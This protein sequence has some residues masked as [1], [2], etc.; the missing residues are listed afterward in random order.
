MAL[1][2]AGASWAYYLDYTGALRTDLLPGYTSGVPLLGGGHW[3][4]HVASVAAWQKTQDVPYHCDL[5]YNSL[6]EALRAEDCTDFLPFLGKG[7]LQRGFLTAEL[8]SA[9]P[10][11]ASDDFLTIRY[12]LAEC[13]CSLQD[14]YFGR[15]CPDQQDLHPTGHPASLPLLP[16]LEGADLEDLHLLR[17]RF[18]Q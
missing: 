12:S 1:G 18:Y 7:V 3:K 9:V 6:D 11:C 8:T 16:L 13:K 15:S 5:N 14:F 17:W 4:D 2:A 10:V